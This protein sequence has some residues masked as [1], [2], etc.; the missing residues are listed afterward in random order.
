MYK[1]E[2]VTKKVSLKK[3]QRNEK[4]KYFF[5]KEKTYLRRE[6]KDSNFFNEQ[7]NNKKKIEKKK[8]KKA[9][10]YI[11]SQNGKIFREK[12]EKFKFL[13]RKMNKNYRRNKN[14]ILLQEI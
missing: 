5:N 10:I 6:N 3:K 7:R 1:K 11:F 2:T 14:E 12:K 13:Y 8:V 9:N 4:D